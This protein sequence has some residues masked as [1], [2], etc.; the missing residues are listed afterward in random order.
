MITQLAEA[1]R[2]PMPFCHWKRGREPDSAT[3]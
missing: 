3:C 2:K 1:T